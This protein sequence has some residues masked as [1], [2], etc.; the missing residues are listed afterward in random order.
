MEP[1]PVKSST[2][3]NNELKSV[4]SKTISG[5]YHHIKNTYIL[6]LKHKFITS[7]VDSNKNKERHHQV[8]MN[9]QATREEVQRLTPVTT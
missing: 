2:I 9:N 5:G 3:D 6:W 4:F 8:G 7:R 1:S